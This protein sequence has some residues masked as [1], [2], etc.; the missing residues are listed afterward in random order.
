MK[1]INCI[2]AGLVKR[3]YVNKGELNISD[4]KRA[5]KIFKKAENSKMML[6]KLEGLTDYI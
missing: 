4:A 3:T 1:L 6:L 2:L 5:K